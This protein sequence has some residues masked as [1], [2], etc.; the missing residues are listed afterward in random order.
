MGPPG[1]AAANCCVSLA[2]SMCTGQPF[3]MNRIRAGRAKPGLMRQHLGCVIAAAEISGAQVQ[4]AELNSQSLIRAR[5]ARAWATTVFIW[6]R[7]AA[8]GCCCRRFGRR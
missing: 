8:A 7:R 4:G 3:S 6:A 1:R 5:Q 2:L